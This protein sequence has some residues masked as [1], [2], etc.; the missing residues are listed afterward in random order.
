[1]RLSRYIHQNPLKAN[2]VNDLKKYRWSS[3]RAYLGLS[4]CPEWLKLEITL[5]RFKR[6]K[7]KGIS[8]QTF[9]ELEDDEKGCQVLTP[10]LANQL[11]KTLRLDLY[12][13]KHSCGNIANCTEKYLSEM[14]G[15]N[16]S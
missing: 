10:I 16:L 15:C 1:M 6:I 12:N 11:N 2:L 13:V 5:E 8:Y 14:I 9:I 7:G 3:Y 4:E